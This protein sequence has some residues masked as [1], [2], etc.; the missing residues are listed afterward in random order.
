MHNQVR[1]S[2]KDSVFEVFLIDQRLFGDKRQK[3][4]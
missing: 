4:P 1:P 2:L 3:R